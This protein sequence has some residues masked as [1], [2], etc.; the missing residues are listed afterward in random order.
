MSHMPAAEQPAPPL[1]RTQWL[2]VVI[3][4]IGFAFDIYELLVMPL[5]ARPALAELLQV[6]PNT[7]VGNETILKWTGYIMYAS[8]VCGG[9]F[10]MLGGYLTDWFGRRRVLVWSIL[11]YAFSALASGFVTSAEWLLFFRCTTFIGVC[12]EFVAAVA[13]LAELF[14]HPQQRERI[15]GYTQAFSSVGGL[16]VTGAYWLCNQIGP[17]L[18]AI[19]GDHSVW[20]YT[21]ISGVIP[22]LPLIIIRPFLPESPAWQLKREQ[23][24]LK[25]PSFKLLFAPEFRRTTIVTAILVACGYGVAFGAIQMTPQIVPGLDPELPQLK[26]KRAQYDQLKESPGPNAPETLKVK[27]ELGK[28]GKKQQDLV[29]TIQFYQEIG[30]LLGRFA[31]AWLALRILSRQRLLRFFI[32]PGLI[33]TPLVYFLPAARNFS[34]DPEINLWA[35]RIGIFLVGFCTVAQFSFWGNYLPR[36]YPVHLRGTG[37]SFAANVGGRM[38]GTGGNPLTTLVIVPLFFAAPAYPPYIGIAYGA[39][40]VGTTMYV[41]AMVFS[42]LLPEPKAESEE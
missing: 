24:T 27:G 40:V 15:L 6:D 36:M 12:V 33:I 17:D 25:R 3:A 35:M 37:E 9:I 13:W 38:F 39:A 14:P 8:A 1:T 18:P 30:G 23:G 10:G 42:F 29:S 26:Q 34:P 7:T 41:L 19:Y 16:L 20:R 21:L 2:I 5:I 31:L 11:L 32:I 22:A 4:A 28:L